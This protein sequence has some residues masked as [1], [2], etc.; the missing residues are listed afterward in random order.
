MSSPLS[1]A[2]LIQR[3]L[4]L[5]G[6]FET[7]LGIPDCY[8]GLAGDF[9]GQGLS[10]GVA[11]WNLGQG[12]LQPLL[13]GMIEKH[14]DVIG[15]LFHERLADLRNMLT[16]PLAEQLRWARS[17]QD[18]PRHN[19][20]E[21][22]KGLFRAL[23]HTPEF[24]AI[25]VEHAAA[26][27]TAAKELCQRFGVST[28]RALALMFDIRVQNHSISPHTETIIRSDFVKLAPDDEVG[29]LRSIANRR[30]EASSPRFVEDV[31]ARKL[32]IA[33][34]RGTV[35]GVSWDLEAQFGIGLHTA[36]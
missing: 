34:G 21:P 10:L 7:S 31:R 2:P 4:A 32:A 20:S 22:W 26:I 15:G 13:A 27:H 12:T 33:N 17:I 8:A 16:S 28:E 36:A 6:A 23:C 29:K 5:T 18:L 1:K 24:Q 30:A 11:Q 3:C 35:H 25:Q 19:I 14:P 9:D